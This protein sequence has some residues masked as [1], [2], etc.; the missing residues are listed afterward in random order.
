MGIL[1]GA[2]AVG[3]TGVKKNSKRGK[4]TQDWGDRMTAGRRGRWGRKNK[5]GF[6]QRRA[7]AVR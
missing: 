4:G 7:A 1:D 3:V 6:R 5:L 2:K